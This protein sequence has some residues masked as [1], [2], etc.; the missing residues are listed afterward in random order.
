M[1]LFGW[2]DHHD[3]GCGRRALVVN[4]W[5]K[6]CISSAPIIQRNSGDGWGRATAHKCSLLV[7]DRLRLMSAWLVDVSDEVVTRGHRASEAVSDAG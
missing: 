1:H 2:L 7:E 4:L 6:R 3:A 5:N